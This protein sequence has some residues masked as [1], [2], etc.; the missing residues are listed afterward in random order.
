MVY[1][2]NPEMVGEIKMMNEFIVSIDGLKKTLTVI[3]HNNVIL[4]GKNLRVRLSKLNQHLY[5]LKMGDKVF[6]ITSNKLSKE[7]F[8]VLVYGHYYETIV[9]TRLQEKA[10]EYLSKKEKQ[11]RKDVIKAPMPG[12]MLKLKKN[13]GD[14]VEIG[15]SVAVLEAMKMENDLRSPASG[16]IKEINVKEGASVEKDEII[17]KIE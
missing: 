9:R 5:L 15:E 4:D 2:I 1:N 11:S 13:V 17:L 6:E 16:I 12:L 8:G 10:I 14:S 7:K 3:D